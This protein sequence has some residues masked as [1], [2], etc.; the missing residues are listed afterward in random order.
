MFSRAVV[1]HSLV[2]TGVSLI[3]RLCGGAILQIASVVF[4]GVPSLPFQFYI[5]CFEVYNCQMGLLCLF[6]AL[7]SRASVRSFSMGFDGG[8]QWL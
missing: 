2:V 6:V 3:F 4:C 8:F 1:E 7:G 5:H